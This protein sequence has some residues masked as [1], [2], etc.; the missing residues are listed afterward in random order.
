MFKLTVRGLL[1]HKLRFALT[2]LAV[3]LGVAFLSGTMVLNDTIKR[4]FDNLFADVNKGTDAALRSKSKL[5]TD[6]GTQRQRIPASLVGRV[7][8]VDGVAREDGKPVVAGQLGFYAQMVDRQGEPIGTPGQGAP[9]FGF[10]WDSFREL[11][12]WRLAAGH[13]PAKD[14]EVVVDKASADSAGFRVGGR[15]RVLSQ[16]S[17]GTYR[18]SGIAKFGDVDSPAGATVV[19]FTPSRAQTITGATN[20]YDAIAV[21]GAPG[22][23]QA[24]LVARI[25][26]TIHDPA[27]QVITGAALTKENQDE[28]AKNLSFFNTAMLI[29]AL[30]ALFVCCFIIF[31]TFSIIVAQRIREMALLRAI[32]ASGLQVRLS[33]LGESVVVGALASVAGLGAGIL[34]SSGLK[35]LLAGFGF[36][37]PAGGTVVNARTVIVAIVVGTVVTFVSAFFPARRAS[38]VP[39]IAAMRD[40]A[41]DRAAHSVVRVAIG[42]AVTGL[43]VVALLVGLFGG[44][45]NG[46]SFVGLGALV[47]FL[48]VALLGPTIARPVSRVLGWPLER[49]KGT[50]GVLAREN[51]ARNPKRTSSTAAALMIGVALVGFITIFASSTKR[52]ISAAVDRAFRA[53]FVVAAKGG[54][55]GGGFSPDLADQIRQLPQ[56]EAAS[57]LRFGAFQA[58]GK[59]KFL[60]AADPSSIDALFDVHTEVGD[61]HQL[62]PT[63]IAIATKVADAKGWKVGDTLHARFPNGA[64]D[65]TITALY[66]TGQ[67]QG[68]SDYFMSLDGFSVAY[69]EQLDNQ[70]YARTKPGVTPVEGRRAIE[71]VVKPYPNAKLEDRAQY[72][73]S[74]EDRVNQLVNLIYALLFL[75]VF[76]AGIGIANTLA[77][78]IVERTRELGLLRAVGMSRAQ[79]RSTIRWEAVII[80]LLGTLLGLGIGLFFGWAIVLALKGQ[81]ITEF[82]PPGLQLLVIVL[83][84]A[85]LAVAFAYFPARRASRLDVLTAISTE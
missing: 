18:I 5:E 23:S 27:I 16:A 58:E 12:P 47:V 65:L 14:D 21:G 33:V 79:L 37:I 70:I 11:S 85:L 41:I 4:T 43:G 49:I 63:G 54:G 61:I 2:A 26:A 74:Q 36:E 32:G 29:F 80:S 82:A 68:L 62:E 38:R 17:P 22:V 55:F 75:A 71:R 84:A 8:R 66:G 15:V 34:L 46:L 13:A 64:R 77:L 42:C 45:K 73:Q 39:P 25:K 40:V 10:T 19:L 30:V 24:T 81:G 76:I 78:S 52:S 6:F 72:K 48:G 28:I 1:S 57:G 67:Q 3:T 31:N 83:L 35:A 50:T 44:V 60:V 69:P 7:G 20:Q 56:V 51:A 9:T 53:D 59:N